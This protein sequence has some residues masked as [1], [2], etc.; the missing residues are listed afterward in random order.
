MLVLYLRLCAALQIT[1]RLQP[2]IKAIQPRFSGPARFWGYFTFLCNQMVTYI[3]N[4]NERRRDV[5]QAIADPVR[6]QILQ[7]VAEKPMHLNAVVAQ[8]DISRP[9]ISRHIRILSECGLLLLKRSGRERHC[10]AEL[11]SLKQVEDWTAQ[12][13]R[14]WTGK[15]DALGAHLSKTAQKQKRNTK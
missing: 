1:K 10:I 6:R 15:L 3:C 9:A 4:M 12:Y 13:R 8:F 5:F 14:F 7:L 2:K 11:K